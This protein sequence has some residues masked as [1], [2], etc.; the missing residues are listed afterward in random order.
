MKRIIIYPLIF[1]LSINFSFA[2][3]YPLKK[4]LVLVEGDYN[5]K[6]YATGQGRQLVQ[7]LGHFN[8]DVTIEGVIKYKTH[9]IDKYDY[10]FY[11][12]FSGSYTM[13]SEF[14][15]DLINT[16]KPVIWINSGFIDFCKKQDVEKRYGFTVSEYENNSIYGF[17]KANDVI[18]IK[19][20]SDINLIQIQ[21]RKA[22]EIWATTF[23]VKPK[24][25]IP[26]MVKSGNLIYV[27]DIPFTGATESDRYLYFADKLHD[28]LGEQHAVNH[29]AIIRIEDV[30]PL[31]D[32]DK[33]REVADILSERGIPFMVGVVPI[34]VDPGEDIRV[35]L[36][37]RPEVVDALKYMVQNGGS[38]VMHGVTHQYRGISTNDYE[39]WDGVT[40]KPIN[41]E[42]PEDIS[43]K[44]ESGLDELIK[45]GIYPVAWETPHYTASNMTYEVVS[46]FFS[47]AV[48]QRMTIENFDYGQYFPYIINHDLYGQKIFPENLGYVP[49]NSNYDSSVVYVNKIIKGSEMIHHV[50]DGIASCFF[51]PFLNLNLLKLLADSL[52][53]D[54]FSFLDLRDY[55]NWVKSHD[56]IILTGSQTYSLNIDNSYLLEIYYDKVGNITKKIF[57][58]ERV[59]GAITKTISLQPGEFYMAE[60][61]DYHIKEPTFKDKALHKFQDTYSDIMGG[62]EWHEARVSVCWNQFAR[63]ASFYDQAS[64]V[65]IFNSLNINVDTIFAGQNLDLNSTNLLVVPYSYINYLTYFDYDKIVRFVKEGGNLI[66]DRRNKLIEKFDIKF[67]NVES[68][69]QLIRDNYFPQEFVSW[70]YSQLVNKF[71]YNDD[72][73]IF[74][75]DA[76]T[77]LAAAIGR[78]YGD[79]K[80]IYFNTMFDPNTPHGYSNYPFAMEYVRKY[81]QLQPVFKREN[82]EVY[83]EPGLRQNT[84]VENLMKIWVKQ[85]I[86]IIHI[87]GWHQYAKYNYDYQRI[88]KLAHANGMLVYAWLEPPYISQKFWEKHPEWREKNFKNDD[89]ISIWRYPVALTEPKC[90]EAV[91]SE[92][93]DF[94]KQYDWDGVNIA[95]LHFEA[96]KGFEDPKLFTPMHPSACKEFKKKYGFDLKDIFNQGSEYYWKTNI[97]A[98][99]DVI[100]YR[101]DKITEFHDQILGE[102]TKFAKSKSGFNV[103]V[104]FLDT[105]FSPE[106]IMYYG[107]NSDKIIELQKKYGFI[108]QP[109]DPISK[110]STEPSRYVEFG[111]T[112]ARKMSDSTKLSIDLNILSFRKKDEVTPFPTLVQ[113]GIESYELINFS[114]IGAPRYTIY[115][116]AT[117]NPQDLSYF[118]YAASS[119]VKYHYTDEGYTVNSPYSFVIQLPPDIKIIT[120]DGQSMM[121]FRD[122]RF[123]ITAGSHTINIEQSNLPG[124]SAVEL[125]PH[126]LSFT[127]NIQELTF[128]M[129]R[130]K[131]SYECNERALVSL[132]SIP[133]IILVDNQ[134]YNFEVLKGNDCFSVFLPV[135]KHT[136]Q[137]ST[138]DKFT[139]G[140]S[141]TSLLSISAIAVYGALAALSLILMYLILK[142]VRRVM[143]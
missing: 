84:S 73:E 92:Y 87:P 27:A 53:N 61:I 24:K 142:I 64:L 119:D 136:V 66:T 77:G 68:R 72:D 14:C 121:G 3:N 127:G 67:F 52:K 36:T 108:L 117:C 34:Y 38:I 2:E 79:G 95:E 42:R 135:G 39:F 99:E 43:K 93:L 123:F 63:G 112:Y 132:N 17:V 31:N 19:G 140:I 45:N 9:D 80:I 11:V 15:A 91:I 126:L 120:V 50:R 88:I 7:L 125:Q 12:G 65:S 133:A 58:P 59:N 10:L 109:E 128:D 139:Y 26:Y 105:Y 130:L 124:F 40:N 49:L 76:N 16:S 1:I 29:Q 56:K 6:S 131:F 78:K 62:N 70:K 41:D 28:I 86:R 94:L 115:S 75:E 18:Y 5:M 106:N 57:S 113:T 4:V 134:K 96:G 21:N 98:K 143:E 116:E 111:R 20:T 90:M 48:E 35:K 54:G 107:V 110:W 82:L 114:S 44:I 101:V 51:H 122:N 55:D 46:K 97:K 25:E 141:L 60:G 23:S 100:K 104:T 103:M 83:F 137:I 8:T 138:G 13:P 89:V 37:E 71:D 22:V 102:V 32:P 33:L 81:F 85:G 129:R 69:L 47:T 30:T 74:C 118:P